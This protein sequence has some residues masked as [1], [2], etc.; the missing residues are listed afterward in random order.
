MNVKA[1]WRSLCSYLSSCAH[2]LFR[3][4]EFKSVMQSE[5]AVPRVIASGKPLLLFQQTNVIFGFQSF[6]D[7]Q[8]MGCTGQDYSNKYPSITTAQHILVTCHTNS[9]LPPAKLT[10]TEPVKGFSDSHRTENFITAFVIHHYWFLN[11]ARRIQ[12]ASVP[13]NFFK[14]LFNKSNISLYSSE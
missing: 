6:P 1:S 8:L 10:N 5:F 2:R 7:E 3:C 12:S 4:S 9:T 11:W 13:S 14:I